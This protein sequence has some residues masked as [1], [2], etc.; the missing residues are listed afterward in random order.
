MHRQPGWSRSLDHY[1]DHFYF[2]VNGVSDR[3]DFDFIELVH[4]KKV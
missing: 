3:A 2:R 4:L 1:T